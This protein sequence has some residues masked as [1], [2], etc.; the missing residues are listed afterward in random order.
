M[1]IKHMTSHIQRELALFTKNE[2]TSKAVE[3]FMLNEDDKDERMKAHLRKGRIVDANGVET[4]E[5]DGKWANYSVLE[6]EE[7]EASNACSHESGSWCDGNWG[8]HY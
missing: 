6:W 7:I 8:K 2:R 5:E 4:F 3:I 1:S